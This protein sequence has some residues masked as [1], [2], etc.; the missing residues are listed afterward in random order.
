MILI[1]LIT[2]YLSGVLASFLLDIKLFKIFCNKIKTSLDFKDY[3]EILKMSLL[4]WFYFYELLEI[5]IK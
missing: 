4:S 1:I 5:E 3:F 2:F